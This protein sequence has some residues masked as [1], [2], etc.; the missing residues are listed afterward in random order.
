MPGIRVPAFA[1][2]NLQLRILG[3][4]ADGYH[5]L[6]TIL[7]SISLHDELELE[8]TRS[9]AIE[10]TV[11]GDAGLAA[12]ST[13]DNL[14]YRALDAAKRE[15]NLKQGVR[16]RLKKM[17]PVGRGLGGGSSDA[18]A[19]L[20]GLRRLAKK[21]IPVARLIEIGGEDRLHSAFAVGA[22]TG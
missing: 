10:L 5:E 4:R 13:K 3:K 14:V 1:K 11:E 8:L 18:A 17:T 20:T 22:R 16:A 12:E 15:L 2:I 19:A 6:R 9:G 21:E 7:Q